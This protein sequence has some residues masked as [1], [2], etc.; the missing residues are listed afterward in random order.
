M[1][2]AA[3]M[4]NGALGGFVAIL[5]AWGF[6]YAVRKQKVPPTADIFVRYGAGGSA[7]QYLMKG[8]ALFLLYGALLGF[9]FSIFYSSVGPLIRSLQVAPSIMIYAVLGAMLVLSYFFREYSSN[10]EID[11]EKASS[12]TAVH[13]VYAAILGIWFGLGAIII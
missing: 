6:M 3:S 10:L 7:Q 11:R 4:A 5:V 1:V 2:T 8:G 9:L 12:F 13:F